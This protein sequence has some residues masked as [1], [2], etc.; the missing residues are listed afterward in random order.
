M[1]QI[2]KE[3]VQNTNRLHIRLAPWCLSIMASLTATQSLANT[4]P[5]IVTT[6]SIATTET[7]SNVP[8]SVSKPVDSSSSPS[9][10][11]SN[12][13]IKTIYHTALDHVTDTWK[14]GKV[15]LFVPFLS[16]HMPFAYS[17]DKRS[18]Y[19]E[20]PAGGGLGLGR[21]NSSG[22]YEGTYAMAFL[23]SHS[24]MSYMAGYAWIPT[25]HIAKSEVKVGVGLTGFLMSRQ[26]YFG[27][28]PFPGVLPLASVSY[29]QLAIQAA[30]VPGGQGN[31]NV[32]FAWG[33]WTFN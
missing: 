8:K 28:F 6:N 10:S 21:Y 32:L 13:N 14:E 17:A 7:F 11:T 27:G 2:I 33:K 1:K 31:G 25:W 9:A 15:E 26:D 20:Y 23:D 3:A 5:S 29:K 4:S 30:Y 19:N 24:D 18:E 16:Y 12:L 22:N